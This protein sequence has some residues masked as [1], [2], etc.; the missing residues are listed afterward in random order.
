MDAHPTGDML[1]EMQMNFDGDG[2]RLDGR[3]F[4]KR[5]NAGARSIYTGV[6]AVNGLKE[7]WLLAPD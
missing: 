1:A 7:A 5:A 4:L 6:G 3:V 2:L